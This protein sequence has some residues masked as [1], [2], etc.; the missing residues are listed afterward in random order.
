MAERIA[1][2]GWMSDVTKAQARRKL[3]A[4]M[5][6][7]GYPDVWRDYGALTIDPKLSAAENVGRAVAFEA[8][9]QLAQIGKPVDRTEWDDA[10]RERLL[11][12]APTDSFPGRDPPAPHVVPPTTSF[13]HGGRMGSDTRSRTAS[14]T[15]VAIRAEGNLKSGGRLRTIAISRAGACVWSSTTPRGRGYYARERTLTL[16]ENIADIGGLTIAYHA[17]KRSLKGKPEPA[18]VDGL[19]PDQRF[20]IGYAQVWRSKTRPEALRTQV[21]T[22]PH[23]PAQWRV[24]GAVADMPEFHRA[25]GCEE[26]DESKNAERATIG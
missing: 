16:G 21:L 22:N 2:A 4:I 8:R 13:E 7:I 5:H 20:F 9:R 23:S 14:T 1:A 24:N 19:T 18:T 6:K 3:N 25:F 17:W 15:R 26:E 10:P 11:Q 12:P